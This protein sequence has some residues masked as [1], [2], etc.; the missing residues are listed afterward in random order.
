[1]ESVNNED[2]VCVYLHVYLSA[3]ILSP[4]SPLWL[5]LNFEAENNRNDLVLQNTGVY[6]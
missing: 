3:H 4:L 6:R 1:M 5:G 2:Q